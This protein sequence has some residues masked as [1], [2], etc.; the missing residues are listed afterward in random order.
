MIPRGSC[1]RREERTSSAR[2]VREPMRSRMM[3]EIEKPVVEWRR[4]LSVSWGS[5]LA[6]L[7]GVVG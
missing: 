5:H 2:E 7:C 4:V 6:M 3:T 1:A